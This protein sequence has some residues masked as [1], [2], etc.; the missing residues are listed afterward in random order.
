VS[1]HPKIRLH[2]YWKSLFSAI[3]LSMIPFIIWDIYFTI[4]KYWGFNPDY[5][6]QTYILHLPV[7]EWLFFIC[8]PYACVFT[9]EALMVLTKNAHLTTKTTK[10]ITVLLLLVFGLVLAFHFDLAYTAVN[11]IFGIIILLLA[12]RY[13]PG[14]LSSFYLTFLVMLIPFFIVNG[15]LTGTGIE[16][17]VVWYNND[18]N[19]GIR[20]LTIP[21]E[22]SVFAFSLILLNLLL[23]KKLKQFDV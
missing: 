5:L 18:E 8:V 6:S 15:I 9:H 14:L 3:A 17:E 23:F 2:H 22:D 11:M 19:L 20:M 4:H 10:I 13:N 16:N 1:F 7:E 21:I 12:Y